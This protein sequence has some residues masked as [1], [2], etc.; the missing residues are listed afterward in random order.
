METM[1]E[2]EEMR[3]QIAILNRKIEKE[4]I[5]SDKLMR[6]VMKANISVVNRNYIVAMVAALFGI[7]YCFWAF[8]LAGI[9]VWFRIATSVFLLVA[10]VYAY[11]TGKD[12]RDRNLMNEN[13]L[14]VRR[15]V[16]KARKTYRDWLKIA[17][18]LISVWLL[19]FFYIV[20]DKIHNYDLA[21]G[22]A[23]GVCLGLALGLKLRSKTMRAYREIIGQIDE[24]TETGR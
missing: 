17:L 21:I 6:K 11:V 2:L 4:A 22:G 3:S 15:K 9:S 19:W 13:L 14:E 8:G 5:I 10:L 16:A 18:P 7:P 23:V 24:L 20:F 1:K 12:M